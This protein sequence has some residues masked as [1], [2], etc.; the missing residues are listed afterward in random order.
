MQQYL[1]Y[2]LRSY[3]ATLETRRD[4][5]LMALLHCLELLRFV[6]KELANRVLPDFE[7]PLLQSPI[8]AVKQPLNVKEESRYLRF[9]RK[10]KKRNSPPKQIEHDVVKSV[11]S[12]LS[13]T[14]STVYESMSDFLSE[15]DRICSSL[16]RSLQKSFRQKLTDWAVSAWSASKITALAG[17]TSTLRQS[18]KQLA[19]PLLNPVD[20]SQYLTKIVT[21]ECY[22][23]PSA[24]FPIL[25]TFEVDRSDECLFCTEVELQRLIGEVESPEEVCYTVE[26]TVGGCFVES[27]SSSVVNVAPDKAMHQ[28]TDQ[29]YSFATR[30]RT[31]PSTLSIRLSSHPKNEPASTS[32]VGYGW[33]DL[34]SSQTVKAAHLYPLPS[35]DSA[36]ESTFEA[37]PSKLHLG[38]R[39][40]QSTPNVS[41]RL[42]LYKHD[43][44]LRQ[45][46]F[47]VQYLRI[48]DQL[49][50]AN[51][52]DLHLLTFNVVPVGTRRG[53]V[54]WVHGSI[55]LSELCESWMPEEP[56]MIRKAGLTKYESIRSGSPNPIQDYLRSCAFDAQA[57]YWINRNVMD[58]YIKSC[59]GYSI[60]T[61][62]LGV[63]DRHL[64]NLL[65]HSSG[66]FFHC[67]YSFL[68]GSDPKTYLPLR[69]TNHMIAALGGE[70]SDGYTK[71][72]SLMGAAFLC[73]RQAENVH[74]VLSLIRLME[75][76]CLP[77]EIRL[78]DVR[79]RLRLD[80]SDEAA[81][82]Y[83]EDLLETTV[84]NKMWLAVDAIHTIGK[85]IKM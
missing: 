41:K 56:S 76:S 33:I 26:M 78:N 73:L 50:Q 20:P 85:R 39:S 3:I 40:R 75:A 25:L 52:L 12:T 70:E 15:L 84:S 83:L 46:A 38:I 30:D 77:M 48:C 13:N 11:S 22:I 35:F 65:I 53:F 82:E 28:W 51:G 66:A 71:F 58:T 68:L 6:E 63:G 5:N 34:T 9:F 45:E 37:C 1:Y 4:G 44:D 29:T 49:L 24:H 55:P 19:S 7:Q 23:L 59:A 62:L 10:K 43:D 60:L 69:I 14:P 36:G 2:T 21:E 64:D 18:L 47:A 74:L 42:L 54:E 79:N 81:L 32:T 61:Y 72:V 67:D 16:E 57:P 31:P 80:L 8:S 27:S 17:V